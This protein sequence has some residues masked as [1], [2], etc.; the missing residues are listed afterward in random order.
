MA[1]TGKPAAQIVRDHWATYGRDVYSRHDYEEV[2]A[3]VAADLMD[4]L[5][6]KLPSL[7]GQRFG[8]F[9]VE[10][11]DDFAYTDPVDG[12]VTLN[13][14][15]RITSMKMPGLSIACP[16]PV[17]PAPPY[18]LS[19]ALLRGVRPHELSTEEV[20][21]GLIAAADQIPYLKVRIGRA[22][23]SVIT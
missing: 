21:A 1:A 22:G 10:A 15:I 2:D 17:R 5:R 16:G 6:E 19:R 12:S 13:Q 14:G 9:T 8:E 23:P 20:L 11:A 18:G 7:P 3:E 4:A